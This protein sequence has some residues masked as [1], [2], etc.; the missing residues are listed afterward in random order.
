M[1]ISEPINSRLLEYTEDS[2][3]AI[4]VYSWDTDYDKYDKV[5]EYGAYYRAKQHVRTYVTPEPRDLLVLD[6]DENFVKFV[7][8]ETDRTFYHAHFD[9]YWVFLNTTTPTIMRVKWGFGFMLWD[10]AFPRTLTDT[11]GPDVF[12]QINFPPAGTSEYIKFTMNGAN[13]DVIKYSGGTSMETPGTV[14]STTTY[15]T[16]QFAVLYPGLIFFDT[17]TQFKATLNGVWSTDEADILSSAFVTQ[18]GGSMD[19]ADD[20]RWE[21]IDTYEPELVLDAKNYTGLAVKN[22]CKFV[23]QGDTAFDTVALGRLQAEAVN[24][25]FIHSDGTVVYELLNYVPDNRRDIRDAAEHY[26]ST[27]VLYSSHQNP[28]QRTQILP[29]ESTVEVELIG[30]QCFLGTIQ[31][32][33][34]VDLGISDFKFSTEFV[35]FSPVEVI[36]NVIHY[37]EGLKVKDYKGKFRFWTTFFD[38]YD[39]LF[40][41]LGGKEV[42]INGSDTFDNCKTDSQDRFAS[43]MLLGRIKKMPLTT[44]KTDDRLGT[45]AEASFVI[46]E[47][48]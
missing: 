28:E 46:R 20:T 40:V 18:F 16:A 23:I 35:D 37:K 41:S 44:V 29:H 4:Q 13:V 34:S 5:V 39:R 19:I 27:V 22:S 12:G 10:Y 24:L 11:Y 14:D 48:V 3:N 45:L 47:I 7:R 33:L 9:K 32:G 38:I 36:F 25:R 17:G 2:A 6:I 15:T 21:L 26:P 30:A 43:T 31:L 42:I 1:T 8:C